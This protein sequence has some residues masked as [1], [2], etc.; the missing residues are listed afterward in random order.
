MKQ[1]LFAILLFCSAF[2]SAQQQGNTQ[3]KPKSDSLKTI[4]ADSLAAADSTKAK[5][6][7]DVDAVV[8]ASAADSLVFNVQK[9]KMNLHGSSELKYKDTDLKSGKIFIDYETNDLEAFGFA[10][11]SDTAKVKLKEAPK[12]IEGGETYDGERLKY[13]FKSQR[14][15]I[16]AAKN[17]TEGQSYIGDKVKKVDKE[18]F[19]VED[20]KF[21]TCNS[22]TPHTYFGASEMKV[23]QKDKI[24]AKWIFMYIGGVPLPLPIPFAVFPNEKG[25]RSG[26]IIPRYGYDKIR[27][28]SFSNF[29]YFMA[30]SDY[31]DFTLTADYYSKGG[32]GLHNRFRYAQRY[33]FTGEINASYS[34]I[35]TGENN[36]PSSFRTD[37]TDW[38]LSWYHNQ[39]INPTTRFD[40]NLQFMSSK[41]FNNNSISYND[42]VSQDIVSNA[43]FSKRWDES[44]T[45]LSINYNRTQNLSRGDIYESLPNVS[46]SK[47]VTYPFKRDDNESVSNQKWY[48]LIGYSY[49][50]Q[51]SNSRKKISGQLNTNA[52]AVHNISISASPKIGYFSIA[53]SFNYTE[54]WYNKRL[55]I[56]NNIVEVV[57]PQTG[58]TFQDK[59]DT[60]SVYGLNFVRTF[61]LSVSAST[62]LYGIF[63]P[64]FLGIESF[65]HTLMPSVSYSYSPD[66]SSDKWGYYDSYKK[67]NGEVVRYDKFGREIFGGGGSGRS[68]SL[69]F[70]LSNIFEM[71][72]T[73]AAGDTAREQ[74]KIQLL[75]ID[76]SI[77]YNLAADSLKLSDLSL[78][79]RTQI[80]ELLNLN[81][82]ST[83]TFYDYAAV[84]NNNYQ[85]I[86][87]YLASNGKGILRITNFGFSV[88]TSLSGEKLKSETQTNQKK[89]DGLN[90]FKKKDYISLYDDGQT[91]DL[92]IPWNLSLSYSYNFS[93]PTPDP[94]EDFSNL[95]ADLGFSITKNWKFT[96]RGS[97]DL[98]R[99][100]ISAPQITVYRD[101][102]EWEM[103]L[104]WNP[105]GAYSGFRFEIRMKAPELQDIKVTKSQGLY[106]GKR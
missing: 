92:T 105:L 57:D 73:K 77:G 95:N 94:G 103:N 29:G 87:Q 43:T 28:Q 11:T 32:Y 16:S 79:Y 58:S 50:G 90:A 81:A 66:F 1:S 23:I 75:R 59:L 45:S 12:L 85:K 102:H 70:S 63:N 19:F 44:G 76:G 99:K 80:G 48:E 31:M 86:N 52:G 69:N 64:N 96:V 54:K 101:L 8:Y 30:I 2:L 82:S 46:F 38:N 36:D 51:F 35:L 67:A 3:S 14:G 98:K 55:Q 74:K 4:G 17:K 62:K 20:G 34:K 104:V 91:P 18:T 42:L 10:D 72:M 49:S 9:K 39:Q 97:Y 89:D 15:F 88:S 22:D 106:S 93:K 5:K 24:V 41:Y 7:Y 84:G 26:I 33:N 68:Q 47:S 56:T 37:K 25:R 6:K 40:V 78:S 13:N 53:P 83:Y 65:R 27:G 60:S 71:K 21:T 61:N 100:Q